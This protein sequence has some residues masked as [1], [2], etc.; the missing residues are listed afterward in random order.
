MDK[1]AMV[2]NWLGRKGLHYIESLTEGEKEK[3]GTL[4]GLFDIFATKFRPQYN[5]TIKSLQFRQLHRIEG[6]AVDEW[7]GRLHMAAA[8]CDYKEI[9]RQLKE[10]FIHSLND[11]GMLGEII[12]E[13][14]IKSNDEQ[15]TSEGVLVWVKRVEAHGAQAVILNDITETCQFDKVKIAPQ[16]K[17][18]QDRIMHKTTNRKPYR[19]CSGIHVPQQCP[20]YGKMCARC[21]KMG[22]YKKVC[23][24][25]KECEVHEIDVE[26]AQEFQDEQIEIV[27]IDSVCS[28]RNQSV[29]TPYLDTFADK[30]KVE[31]PY[32]IDTGSEGNIMPLYIF[33]KIFKNNMLAQLK[34]SIKNHIR[35][36]T[37]NGT[38]ITQ[39]GTCAVFIKF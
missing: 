31:I 24:S 5:Q 33:K 10:Q 22:H 26:V 7:T 27:S 29:I 37:Y 18:G 1:I 11:K 39:L 32:K 13:P 17:N 6:E 4:E 20:A 12:K 38:S 19:Y 14:T 25:R 2:K 35:L 30:N 34:Q 21:R 16:S 8:E 3:C 23:R 9:D 28:N 36:H 15:T